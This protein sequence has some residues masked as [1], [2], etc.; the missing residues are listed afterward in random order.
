MV[1]IDIVQYI[2]YDFFY[3][4]YGKEKQLNLEFGDLEN[5]DFAFT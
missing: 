5:G 1:D 2:D 3:P 4:Y